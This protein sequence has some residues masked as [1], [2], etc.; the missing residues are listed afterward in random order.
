M[1]NRED[2]VVLRKEADHVAEADVKSLRS[3]LDD[4]ETERDT[5]RDVA[6]RA[7]EAL[8][9]ANVEIETLREEVKDLRAEVDVYRS[10]L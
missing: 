5:Y 8:E 7:I 2:P 3:G 9:E 4:L 1:P 6:Y 10:S